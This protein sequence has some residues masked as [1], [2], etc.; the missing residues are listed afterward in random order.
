MVF[1]VLAL[2]IVSVL[3]VVVDVAGRAAR[4]TSV[5][6]ADKLGTIRTREA[7]AGNPGNVLAVAALAA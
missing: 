4:L 6:H 5:I 3:P 2:L 1:R 7:R